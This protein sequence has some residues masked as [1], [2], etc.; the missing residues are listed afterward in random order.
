MSDLIV[1]GAGGH[2]KVVAE[3]ALSAG[4]ASRIA[5]LDDSSSS[6]VLGWPVLGNLYQA[7][8]PSIKELFPLA[9]VA[10]GHPA[11]RLLWMARLQAAGYNLPI[12]IH[13]A[14]SI[15]PSAQIGTA[16]MVCAQAAVQAQAMIGMGAILNTGC[17]VDHDSQLAHGVHVCPGAHIA[18][19]VQVGSRSWIG[20][21]AS[22]I[23]KVHIGSDVT[24]GAGAAV[25][26][27]LPDGVTAVGVPARVLSST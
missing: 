13:P 8:E 12:L 1:L 9:F 26:R 7:L 16:S 3:T 18:G 25:V 14:A 24:V 5:F 4:I 23:H 11:T 17:S 10:I 21:G 22:V 15:S 20:I 2:A 6:R 19:E 27:D